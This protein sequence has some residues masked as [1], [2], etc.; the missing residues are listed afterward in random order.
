M[1]GRICSPR[2]YT[3][4]M[5]WS[6]SSAAPINCT[7]TGHLIIIMTNTSLSISVSCTKM[8]QTKFYV[9]VYNYAQHFHVP[10]C[11]YMYM[12]VRLCLFV[13]LGQQQIYHNTFARFPTFPLHFWATPLP[14]PL[15]LLCVQV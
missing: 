10:Y 7:L 4:R 2:G 11:T 5:T 3:R 8:C 14:L 1:S 9:H 6:C 15:A 13:C 12:Y